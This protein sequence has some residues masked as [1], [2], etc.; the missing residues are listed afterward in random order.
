MPALFQNNPVEILL[1]AAD[2]NALAESLGV[3]GGGDIGDLRVVHRDA[4]LLDIAAGLGLGG[5]E[6]GLDEDAQNIKPAV[7]EIG[8]AQLGRGDVAALGSAC[9][10]RLCGGLG[11]LGLLLAVDETWSA[12]RPGSPWRG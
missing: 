4:A 7:N 12:R 1:A 10:E 2:H 5:A 8:V 11:L 3:V 9:E 6:A